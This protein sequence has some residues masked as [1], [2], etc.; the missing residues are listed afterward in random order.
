[1]DLERVRRL[2]TLFAI[3]LACSVYMMLVIDAM[4]PR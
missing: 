2:L 1:M 4:N 3:I